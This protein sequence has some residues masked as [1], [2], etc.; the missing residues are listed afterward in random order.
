MLKKR[1]QLFLPLNLA[2]SR[3][4]ILKSLGFRPFQVLSSLSLP[5]PRVL[6][7]QFKNEL[8]HFPA[9]FCFLS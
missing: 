1:T 9:T 8:S 5:R 2:K 3:V 6:G 7:F 4:V